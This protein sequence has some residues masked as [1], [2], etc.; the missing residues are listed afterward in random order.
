M[1]GKD[2][3]KATAVMAVHNGE[4]TLSSAIESIRSQTLESWE[5]LVVDDAS[6]DSTPQI[7]EHYEPDSRISVI[8]LKKNVGAGRARNIA[9]SRARSSLIAVADADDLS[10]PERF[11]LQ[12][13][14]M[15]ERQEVDVCGSQMAE[16]GAWSA[17]LLDSVAS[18]WPTE[19]CE[20]SSR[21]RALKM[22][23]PHPTMMFRTDVFRSVGGYPENIRRAEDYGLLLKIREMRFH[24]IDEI[25]VDY[26]TV[27]PLPL[28]YALVS[29]RDA[30]K[31]RRAEGLTTKLEDV[32]P[33]SVDSRSIA[34]WVK[35]RMRE[36]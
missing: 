15:S 14:L 13:A 8:S 32:F 12:C 2:E 18:R 11:A 24:M 1:R 28:S 36:L 21:I 22:P 26:R 3:V 10:R 5:L 7:L 23:I 20:V 25:L 6:T 17:D 29:G 33:L 30:L 27:R 35:R 9:I 34:Q 16:F 4:A 31:A 19:P